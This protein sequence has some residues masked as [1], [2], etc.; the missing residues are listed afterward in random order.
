LP[1]QDRG[2]MANFGAPAAKLIHVMAV[3]FG[4]EKY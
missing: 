4:L 3:N 2:G 1:A